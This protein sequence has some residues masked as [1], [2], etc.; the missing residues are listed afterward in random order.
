MVQLVEQMRRGE[1]GMILID[2]ANPAYSLPGGLGFADALRNVP[3]SVS[4]S[5]FPDDTSRLCR[6]I[7]PDHH[8]LEAWGDYV[9]GRGDDRAGAAGD[10]PGVQHQAGG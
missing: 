2:G 5:S 10:A 1:I 6:M 9:A 7:L 8:F 4:F 3:M